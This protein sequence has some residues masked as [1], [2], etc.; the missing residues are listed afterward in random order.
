VSGT[1]D[2]DRRKIDHRFGDKF[3]P[4]KSAPI[5]EPSGGYTVDE[6]EETPPTRAP[7][8]Q[9]PEMMP[10]IATGSATE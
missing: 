7:S 8:A 5:P 1:V 4:R 9:T 2:R 10:D 6:P 3:D